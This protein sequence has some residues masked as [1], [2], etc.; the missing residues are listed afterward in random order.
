MSVIKPIALT[1]TSQRLKMRDDDFQ[2]IAKFAKSEAGL[3]F[4][5]QKAPMM[6]SRLIKRLKV[7]GLNSF[8][9]YCTLIETSGD[10]N[11]KTELISALT[12]NVTSFF[13]EP[14]HFKILME[15][16][17]PELKKRLELGEPVR[18][19]SAGC[20]RGH[21]PYSIAMQLYDAIP[22]LAIYDLKILATDID[23]KVL[24]FARQGVYDTTE[25]ANLPDGYKEK[26][27][28]KTLSGAQINTEIR[29]LIKFN[30]LNLLKDWPMK[31]QFDLIFCRN[32]VIYFDQDTQDSLWPKF[33][34]ANRKEG[35]LFIG[36]SERLTNAVAPD[37][38]SAGMTA[39]QKQSSK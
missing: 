17:I 2:R 8:E 1:E 4:T 22:N 28:S 10:T 3:L 21:E 23:P 6:E 38:R 37:Y 36:H 30:P 5:Q 26:F 7:L 31:N 20:S 14:H 27:F 24:L 39:Y 16:V 35:W 15:Q 11:E 32:V 19:W 29:Q 25:L 12:T 34:N 33:Q 13:R 9:E 18:I